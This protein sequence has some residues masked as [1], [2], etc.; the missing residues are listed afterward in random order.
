MVAVTVV[1]CI[2]GA[3]EAER[4]FRH[5]TPRWP[6]GVVAGFHNV[7]GLTGAVALGGYTWQD[8]VD[9]LEQFLQ[10]FD[11]ERIFLLGMSGGATLALAYLATHP[12]A[13]AGAG[14]IEPAWSFLPL[15]AVEEAY[16]V[17]LDRVLELPPARQRDAF[18]RLLVSTDVR[19][20]AVTALA[21]RG[22]EQ[23]RQPGET[24]LA[25]V[26]R[27]MR[28]HPVRPAQLTAFPGPVYLAVGGR[29]N[30]M[31]AAQA[32]QIQAAIAQTVVE[33]YPDRHH[34][35]APHHAQAHHLVDSLLSTWRIR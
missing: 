31:W 12:D 35:D 16:F 2:P 22:Y 29:S 17:E 4:S 7:A 27:A 9:R 1:V 11:D 33:T 8:E 13:I 5:V 21:A 24:A 34:L 14:L 30:P 6:R 15:S 25:V 20:P 28:V 26:T 32:E 19:L 18:V 10:R 3:S 23:A